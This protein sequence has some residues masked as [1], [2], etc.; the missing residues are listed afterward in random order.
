VSVPWVPTLQLGVAATSMGPALQVKNAA[1]RDPAPTRVRVGVAYEVLQH[2][3]ADS[4]LQLIASADLQRGVRAGIEPAAA[5]GLE[6]IM[7]H[8]LF[9]RGGYARGRG[10]GRGTAL[11]VGCMCYRFDVRVAK[12]F[13]DYEVST[14]PF[15]ITFAVR[16]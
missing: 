12:S 16:F 4:T 8:T 13:F 3:H 9:L 5:V 1:Q 10:Q 2:F 15:Q 11:C 14:E 6:L 7:D